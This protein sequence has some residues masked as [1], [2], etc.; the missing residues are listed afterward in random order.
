MRI[1][2]LF[3]ILLG[4]L[5]TANAQ[6]LSKN[7]TVAER[8]RLEI[9]NRYGQVRVAVDETL[10]DKVWVESP[11]AAEKNLTVNA[12]LNNISITV[13]ETR[14]RLDLSLRVPPRTRLK[15]SSADGEITVL[16]NLESAEI[17]TV[18]GTIYAD[19]PT[20]QLKYNFL[21]TS[22]RPR[23]LSDLEL[24][25][26]KEKAG[27]KF[28]IEGR[29]PDKEKEK[30]KKGE[31]EKEEQ[32]KT[33]E[34]ENSIEETTESEESKDKKSKDKGQRTKDKLVAL[35]FSTARGVILLN[36]PPS[37][38]PSDLTERKLTEA[39]KAI[40]KSGDS[41]LTEAVRKVSP[42]HF[43]DYLRTLPPRK[44][45]PAFTYR[46]NA[47]EII[48]NIDT[49]RRVNVSVADRYGRSLAALQKTDF[50][51]FEGGAEREILDVQ[52]AV[53]PFNL[54]LLLDVSGSVEERIDF[55]RKAA[56]NFINTVSPQDKLAIVVFRDDVQVLTS[57][58][59]DKRVL[60]ESLDTFDAGGGTAMYD[61]LAFILAD[62]L[63]PM[64][65]E[66]TAVVVLSDGDDNRS[67]IP[68]EPLIG[69]VQ[70]SGALIYPLYIPSG[71][72]PAATAP[73]ADQT[74]DPLRSRY[75]SLTS[76]AEAEA[77]RLAEVSGG[78]YFPI[79]RLEDLQRAYDDVV[80]QLRTAY[81]VT[82]RSK[83]GAQQRLRITVK[84]EGA[85]VR[86]G[87]SVEI[88]QTAAKA[89]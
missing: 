75:L 11:Q 33:V 22:S 52:P 31:E 40:V 59:Q 34:V 55:I 79:L 84:R 48:A 83:S 89:N 72:I 3:V 49:L 8:P 7:F 28:G 12:A 70:E 61:S 73:E 27:G 5:A 20:E 42:K 53:T 54:V 14:Q 44:A 9:E 82:Y 37:E 15:I 2:V 32:S 69:A 51:L 19:V 67:F 88:A 77:K 85:F 38:V 74:I 10:T 1:A 86:A 35:N 58:S 46:E 45:S 50:T 16:G 78:A 18:T 30:G 80:A 13:N 64:R 17:S 81:S 36:V 4:A 76:K 41:V 23:F 21:W 25:E 57:F 62:T 24:P 71:L 26:V 6:T 56:R 43:G 29:F 66:R 47:K 65:G 68:F 87:T 39:V 60:S 63:R